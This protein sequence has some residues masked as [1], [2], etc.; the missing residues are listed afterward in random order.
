MTEYPQ[1]SLTVDVVLLCWKKSQ[2]Y[3]LLIQRKNNPFKGK[4]A[5]PGGYVDK[6]EHAPDAAR[7]ELL[8]ETGV[9]IDS[10]APVNLFD[11]AGRDPRGWCV[12]M[13]FWG[14]ISSSQKAVAGS[15]AKN[16]KWFPLD[17][18]PA[19]AFDHAD[20]IDQAKKQITIYAHSSQQLLQGI[21]AISVKN[22]KAIINHL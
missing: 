19:L 12:S 6:D 13:A 5:L 7:R 1:P 16:V 22:L 20:I 10:L 8:E 4:W 2:L 17:K 15:D 21:G 11:K 3:T 18:L 9:E 14:V